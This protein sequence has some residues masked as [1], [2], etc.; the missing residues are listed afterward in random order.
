MGAVIPDFSK[1]NQ[2]LR[3]FIKYRFLAHTGTATPNSTSSP[4]TKASIA[5]Q[6]PAAIPMITSHRTSRFLGPVIPP[7]HQY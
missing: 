6:R 7:F 3:F 2:Q 4:T 1:T 5:P